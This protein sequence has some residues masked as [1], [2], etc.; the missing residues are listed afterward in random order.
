MILPR[1]FDV[2]WLQSSLPPW[3]VE[4]RQCGEMMRIAIRAYALCCGI[5]HGQRDSS[6]LL[7]QRSIGSVEALNDL[8][9]FYF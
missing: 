1:L 3:F 2:D 6:G 5:A 7:L 9:F 4:R 8:E